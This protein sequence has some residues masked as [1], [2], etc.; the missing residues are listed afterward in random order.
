MGR[1]LKNLDSPYGWQLPPNGSLIS[2]SPTG[3]LARCRGRECEWL[4][5]EEERRDDLGRA[6]NE[7]SRSE[8]AV[9]QNRLQVDD[10]R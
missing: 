8:T 5:R 1:G 10:F 9:G 3:R 2:R 4:L 6:E 7:K